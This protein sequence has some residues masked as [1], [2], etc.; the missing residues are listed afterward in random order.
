MKIKYTRKFKTR[1]EAIVEFIAKDSS[2]RAVKFSAEL[3]KSIN[4]IKFMP[5]KH[6]KSHTADSE[7]IRDLIFKGYVIPFFI[8]T[9]EN[10]VEILTIY[11][12]NRP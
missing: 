1:I 10:V 8:N 3:F 12:K 5:Y 2:A 9:E 7:N 4:E 6:R 11:S